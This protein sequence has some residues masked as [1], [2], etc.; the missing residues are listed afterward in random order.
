MKMLINEAKLLSDMHLAF[1]DK[2]S[3]IRELMQ[4]GKRAKAT[5]I[6]I[7]YH[8]ESGRLVVKNNGAVLHNFQDLLSVSSS[9]W[10]GEIKKQ[11][12]PYGLGFL[13]VLMSSESEVMIESGNKIMTVDPKDLL[14]GADVGEPK[15]YVTD[16][17]PYVHGV[18]ISLVIKGL[19]TYKIRN[20]F[21]FF[22]TDITVMFNES[23][24]TRED[25]KHTFVL[26][27]YGVLEIT[28]DFSYVRGLHSEYRQVPVCF[29]GF[30]TN[31]VSDRN[32]DMDGLVVHLDQNKFD[33]RLPD[34]ATIINYAEIE[35]GLATEVASVVLEKIKELPDREKL[36]CYRTL[37]ELDMLNL[38]EVVDELA[39]QA[40]L[41]VNDVDMLSFDALQD[42]SK[43]WGQSSV[44]VKS[45]E[46]RVFK[47]D[48]LQVDREN[49]PLFLSAHITGGAVCL[50]K[51]ETLPLS[52]EEMN[53]PCES[54]CVDL[55]IQYVLDAEDEDA[56][57]AYV[58]NSPECEEDFI[59]FDGKALYVNVCEGIE[60]DEAMIRQ[61]LLQTYSYQTDYNSELN[62]AS[63]DS[64][65]EIVHQAITSYVMIRDGE[66][67]SLEQVLLEAIRRSAPGFQIPQ[68]LKG[69]TVTFG[70]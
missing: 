50:Y 25:P 49:F 24:C 57:E 47:V 30:K 44:Y 33:A 66:Q 51:G 8:E 64:D 19:K 22:P 35:K 28:K 61:V 21:D 65:V 17:N 34:R 13:S 63:L 70:E 31:Q 9:G 4:N 68:Q 36:E 18:E 59:R 5:V 40:S 55:N 20:L 27:D 26:P 3:P 56:L 54:S 60:L 15:E 53:L 11:E 7:S 43:G 39:P 69:K 6:T 38:L 42:N 37:R 23:D 67:K 48:R 32:S 2:Y 45:S 10:S 52:H 29:Q 41:Q 1:T 62:T 46:C 58:Y 12:K 14:T 16:D